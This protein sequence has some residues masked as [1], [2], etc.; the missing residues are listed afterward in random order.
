MRLFE[1]RRPAVQVDTSSAAIRTEVE[2]MQ[3]QEFALNIR[4][5]TGIVTLV[6]GLECLVGGAG[7]QAVLPDPVVINQHQPAAAH[8]M[9]AA[10]NGSQ[11]STRRRHPCNR[12]L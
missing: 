12:T 7:T 3:I 1:V 8:V 5:S 4:N 2:S 6:P 10:A 11:L 9:E